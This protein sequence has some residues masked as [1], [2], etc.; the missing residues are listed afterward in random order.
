MSW[1]SSIL[2]NEYE[3]YK[4]NN[5]LN[6][7]FSIYI[8]ITHITYISITHIIFLHILLYFYIR[9]YTTYLTY[10]IRIFQYILKSINIRSI[11]ITVYVYT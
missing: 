1:N 11:I 8:I 9:L 3:R 10:A 5:V 4:R 7:T 6:I 2:H